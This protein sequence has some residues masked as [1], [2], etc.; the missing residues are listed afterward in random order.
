MI[1]SVLLKWLSKINKQKVII[2]FTLFILIFL[3]QSIK[4]IAQDFLISVTKPFYIMGFHLDYFF[5]NT[6]SFNLQQISNFFIHSV[7]T[8][9]ILT[10]CIF[11]YLVLIMYMPEKLNKMLWGLTFISAGIISNLM[12]KIRYGFVFDF[13]SF[14]F[15]YLKNIYFNFADVIQLIGWFIVII[16]GVKYRKFIFRKHELRNTLIVFKDQYYLISFVS[17]ITI[18]VCIIFFLFNYQYINLISEQ[19]ARPDTVDFFLYYGLV[20]SLVIIVPITITTVYLSNKIYGPVYAFERHMRA[21]MRGEKIPP[22][23]LRDKDHMKHLEK[24]S[25]ELEDKIKP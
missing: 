17:W 12:D 11:I 22:L 5:N 20:V 24:L 19:S 25:R 8:A 15:S 16:F 23:K 21:V 7:L 3:D 14:Q 10:L 1:R 6:W 4:Q 13:I 9:G 2:I 18:C